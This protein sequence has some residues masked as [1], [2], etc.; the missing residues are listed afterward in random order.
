V[1]T[2]RGMELGETL[3][4]ARDLFADLDLPDLPR[5]WIEGLPGNPELGVRLLSDLA[6]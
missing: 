1:L 3:G 6:R 4:I 2:R 5:T